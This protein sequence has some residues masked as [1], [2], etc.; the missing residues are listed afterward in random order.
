MSRLKSSKPLLLLPTDLK[1]LD[2]SSEHEGQWCPLGLGVH[3]CLNLSHAS[4]SLWELSRV[5]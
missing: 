2:L 4:S 3:L 5:A 1:H